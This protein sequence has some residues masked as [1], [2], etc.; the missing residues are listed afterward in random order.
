MKRDWHLIKKILIA[1]EEMETTCGK[2]PPE[3]TGYDEETA[4][5]HINLLHQAGLITASCVGNGTSP[6]HCWA[7][8][9]TWE[10]H[11]FIDSIRSD[12][13]WNRITKT[14]REKGLDLSFALI[15]AIAE[16]VIKGLI[17]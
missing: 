14:A 17:T 1:V 7:H 16:G 12:T 3:F 4:S 11:E 6:L 10:G 9:L 5:Y 2:L 15:K 13:A 8:S